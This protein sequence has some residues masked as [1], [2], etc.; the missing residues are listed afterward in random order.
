MS[1]LRDVFRSLTCRAWMEAPDGQ[2]FPERTAHFMNV[3]GAIE[4]LSGND[5]VIKI[6]SVIASNIIY[7]YIYTNIYISL[8]LENEP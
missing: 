5:T 4:R 6:S 8:I 7:I 1:T 3:Y 2:S